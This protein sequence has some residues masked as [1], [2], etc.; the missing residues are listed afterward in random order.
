MTNALYPGDHFNPTVKKVG[1]G[2]GASRPVM[3]CQVSRLGCYHLAMVANPGKE[4]A[5]FGQLYFTVQTSTPPN[6]AHLC[7]PFPMTL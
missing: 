7:L 4:Q 1:T 6:S 5:A 3:D 2:S